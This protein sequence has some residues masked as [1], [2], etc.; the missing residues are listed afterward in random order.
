LAGIERVVHEI[1]TGLAELDDDL[2]VH[3]VFATHYADD[4]L[5]ETRYTK[6][7][8][9][10]ERLRRL[11]GG[12]RACVAANDFDVLVV[13]QVEASVIAWLATRGLRLPV[14]VTHLHGNPRIEE[15]EGTRRTRAA[16]AVFRRVIARRIA[17]VL[18]VSPSLG[19]FA[20]T[21]IAPRTP[22]HVLKNPMRELTAAPREDGEGL[23]RLLSVGRLSRQKGQDILMRALAI[24]RPDLPRV[25]LTL[26]GNGPEEPVLRAL[27][28]DLGLDDIVTFAGYV[29]DPADH[30]RSADCFVLPS[31]WEGFGMVVLEALHF[32]LPVLAADCEFGPGD[33][34]TE[35][36]IGELVAPD[37][38]TA[39]AEGLRNVADGGCGADHLAEV[40]R[41]A[42]ATEYGRAAVA[43]THITALRQIVASRPG[44]APH[45][46]A[47]VEV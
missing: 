34:V 43:E 42:V 33:V 35:Q 4:L 31:R 24:A 1:A 23:L 37:S 45:L 3:V 10:V 7:V 14:F 21:E 16:F 36:A 40:R 13:P 5:V 26:V 44:L 39:L 19:A 30:F 47:F 9:R 11:A 41:R 29:A 20:A 17:A 38:P 18:A 15:A 8:L 2:D 32:G 28:T 27:C 46:A 6:H 12:L 22:V 25:H